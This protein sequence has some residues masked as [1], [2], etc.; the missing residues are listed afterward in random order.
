VDDVFAL[1]GKLLIAMPAIGDPRF[2]K[3]V[4]LVC[5]HSEDGTM[6]LIVNKPTPDVRVRNLLEQL[7]IPIGPTLKNSQVYFGGPVEHGRGFV[8]HSTEFKSEI[9]T[10]AIDGQFA[11]TAT[12]DVLEAI[13]SD[14]GPEM[15]IT[16]LG[17][18]GWG[19]GQLETELAQ[20]VWLTTDASPD[21]IFNTSD[22]DKWSAALNA[23]G[24]NG[25]TLSG[26]AGRA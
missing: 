24:I 6:G 14:R 2:E 3:T 21:L 16:A 18:A 25:L 9:S 19:P 22:D 15:A 20:N 5:A 7:D 4:V 12:Q 11:M 26:S 10:L 17:Y 8:L 1:T 13:A 23:M